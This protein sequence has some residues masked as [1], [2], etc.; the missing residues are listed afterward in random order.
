[1]THI[2]LSKG[3]IVRFKG[4]PPKVLAVTTLR[5]LAS[6]SN[7]EV[8]FFGDDTNIV[9][10]DEIG[11][12]RA[13]RGEGSTALFTGVVAGLA[14]EILVISPEAIGAGLKTNIKIEIRR[15]PSS[16]LYRADKHYRHRLCSSV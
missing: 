3:V 15:L 11:A 10:T 5:D 1:M 9:C 6:S 16:N 2:A 13:L 4:V 8:T 12:A 14:L 7:Q